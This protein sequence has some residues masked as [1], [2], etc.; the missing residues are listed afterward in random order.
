MKIIH[1]SIKNSIAI[2]DA[3]SS[4]RCSEFKTNRNRKSKTNKQT[5]YRS[6]G[7]ERDA[8]ALRDKDGYKNNQP[9]NNG[10]QRANQKD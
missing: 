2:C 1:R 9:Q 8:F 4:V 5:I 3:S 7:G 10:D 6:L